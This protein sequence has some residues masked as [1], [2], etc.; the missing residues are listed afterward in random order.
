MQQ[1][2]TRLV[3]VAGA[4]LL[5]MLAGQRMWVAAYWETHPEE[6]RSALML[7]AKYPLEEVAKSAEKAR[8]DHQREAQAKREQAL[9]QMLNSPAQGQH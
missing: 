9:N 1:V 5:V 6:R 2:L 3:V 4:T 8:L 7:E